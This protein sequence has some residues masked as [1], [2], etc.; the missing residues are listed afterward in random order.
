MLQQCGGVAN[1]CSQLLYCFN[2][3]KKGIVQLLVL[4]FYNEKP[5]SPQ[6]SEFG[7]VATSLGLKH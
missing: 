3:R 6:Y 2:H 5:K 1:H 7:S 4:T